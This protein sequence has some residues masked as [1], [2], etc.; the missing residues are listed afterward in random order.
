VLAS[1]ILVVDKKLGLQ[2]VEPVELGKQIGRRHGD[3]PDRV[4]G[5]L[6]LP[7]RKGSPRGI[8]FEIVHLPV[9][10]IE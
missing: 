7:R 6:R 2:D 8:E 4:V 9:T 3:G 1:K 5:I 10:G